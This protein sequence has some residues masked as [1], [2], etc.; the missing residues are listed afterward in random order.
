MNLISAIII[1]FQKNEIDKF[2]CYYNEPIK[3]F[4]KNRFDPYVEVVNEILSFL[5]EYKITKRD[6]VGFRAFYEA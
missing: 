5:I 3:F 4:M 2:S 1:F 6:Y